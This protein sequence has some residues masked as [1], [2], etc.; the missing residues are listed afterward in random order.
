MIRTMKQKVKQVI[1][2][3]KT[4]DFKGVLRLHSEGTYLMMYSCTDCKKDIVLERGTKED[5]LTKGEKNYDRDYSYA[6]GA[7]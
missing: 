3:H 6:K 7:I 5:Q 2:S 4:K 1:C